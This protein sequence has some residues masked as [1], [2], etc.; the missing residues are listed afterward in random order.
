MRKNFITAT[1]MAA[2]VTLGAFPAIAAAQGRGG[3]N[4]RGPQ[5][6][7]PTQQA[8]PAPRAQ[9]PAPDRNRGQAVPR[10]Q[11]RIEE[12]RSVAPLT[13]IGPSV[14]VIRPRTSFSLGFS[15]GYP[16]YSYV[17]YAYPYN[18]YPYGYG[19]SY[20]ASRYGGLRITGAPRYAEVLAD[21]Y[22]VGVVDNFD[23]IFQSLELSPGP[24]RIEI[25]ANGYD[26]YVVDVYIQPGRT[27]TFHADMY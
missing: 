23:G 26:D 6:G 3:D 15:F 13:R 11:S 14:R 7:Q 9:Q 16:R 20:Y 24:H 1:V 17:P 10:P 12:F 21:G 22:Y 27:L 18:A 25:R 19:P 8:R 4:R 2:A 5:R